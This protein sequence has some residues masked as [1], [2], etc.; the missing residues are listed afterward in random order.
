MNLPKLSV[1]NPVAVNLLMLGVMVG[2]VYVSLVMTRELFPQWEMEMVAVGAV[3]P[4]ASPLEVEK[5]VTIKIEEEIEDVDGIKKIESNILEGGT[6]IIVSFDSGYDMNR[7]LNDIKTEIDKIDTLPDEVEDMDI[8]E[9]DP[10]YPV[11]SV[12]IY[13]DLEEHKLK[14][15]AEEIEEDLIAFPNITEIL[16]TG[17]RKEE[18]AVEIDPDKL[19][20]YGLT[21]REVASAIGFSN[22]DIP[23]GEL[24]TPQ[25]KIRVRTLGE[26]D[27]IRRLEDIII[28]SDITGKQVK[29]GQVARVVEGFEETEKRGRFQGHRAALVNVYKTSDQDAIDI[30]DTVKEYVIEKQEELGQNLG[31]STTMDMSEFIRGRL[32]LMSRNAKWG[33]LLMFLSL[34][35]FLELRVAFWIALGLPIS[36]MGTFIVMRM[37]GGSF[38]M[39]SMFSLIIVLGM[40][41]DDAIIIGENVYRHIETGMSPHR[42]AVQGANEVTKPV[43]AAI[44]TT[45]AAF[46]PLM[47]MEGMMGKFMRVIPFVVIVALSVSLIEAFGILPSHLAEFVRKRVKKDLPAHDGRNLF[48]RISAWVGDT[49][50][51]FVKGW[52]TDTY[53]KLLRFAL[54]WRYVSVAAFMGAMILTLGLVVSGRVPFVLFQDMDSDWIIA[55][56][57]MPPGTTANRTEEIVA[58]IDSIAMEIPEA[59]YVSSVV[60]SHWDDW[61]RPVTADPAT[62][63][64]VTLELYQAGERERSSREIVADLK[65]RVGVIP[66]IASLKY[67]E[68][69]GGIGGPEIEILV[70]GE[71]LAMVGRGVDHIKAELATYEG[72]GDIEDNLKMG[73]LE[74]RIELKPSARALGLT[75]RD[76]A[77]QLR[78]AVFGLKAQTLQRGRDEV[79]VYVRLEGAARNNLADIEQLRI[80]TPA[81]GRVPFSEVAGFVTDRGYAALARV[82]RKRAVTVAADVDQEIANVKE[83]TASLISRLENFSDEFRGLSVSFQGRQKESIESLGSLR[84]GFLVALGMIYAILASLFRSYF[85]P[86]VVMVSIPFAIV[87]AVLGHLLW[88]LPL[89]MLSMIGI[90]ALTGIVVNDSLLLVDFVNRQRREGVRLLEAIVTGGRFRMRPIILT[91]ITTVLGL[92]PMLFE[93][94]FQA[95]FLI[96]LALSIVAGLAFAT[97]LTLLLLPC[98][99][100]IFEDIKAMVRWIWTGKFTHPEL[101]EPELDLP[102]S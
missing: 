49:R 46:M 20:E 1:Q 87:G 35:V 72:V 97:V 99:Y 78:S 38:N 65:E 41:V 85:Q 64:E 58:R 86:I 2:G 60:G 16:V 25:G 5:G 62:L 90:V 81:G 36:F 76:L 37:T 73:N 95:R 3:Y 51:R 7:A 42:A 45:I 15:L 67:Q 61:G 4:G 27:E 17:V 6:G 14:D 29:V 83:I 26:E 102:A 8:R 33:L 68:R 30:A 53:E 84:V 94:S 40:I 24:R 66:G 77:W 59:R 9:V 56:L 43:V 34:A 28:R 63:G 39:M 79:D 93:T 12:A 18:I 32:S 52:L 22:L 70:Q 19:E 89:T 92:T 71:N 98:V 44:L 55:S 31:I 69:Q 48:K 101:T 100:F 96:P 50:E 74:A 13:G 10:P 23:G 54:S 91:S 57:E 47:F 21:Y 11:I 80:A 88:G 82:D 75:V